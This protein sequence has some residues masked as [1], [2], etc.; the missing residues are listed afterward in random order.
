M[1]TLS[2]STSARTLSANYVGTD[3]KIKSDTY[4]LED[5]G[6]IY[7]SE[8]FKS[9]EDV[10]INNYS[11]IYLTDKR[12]GSDFLEFDLVSEKKLQDI[13]TPI[14]FNTCDSGDGLYLYIDETTTDVNKELYPCT[15]LAEK[16]IYNNSRKYF[17]IQI[18]D[19]VYCRIAH[20]IEGDIFYLTANS[21]DE[22]F[23][24]KDSP[25]FNN[26]VDDTVFEYFID[27]D[28]LALVKEISA[29][30]D[31]IYRRVLS[32]N[33]NKLTLNN[34][35]SG[36]G[37]L[38]FSTNS[39]FRINN[40]SKNKNLLPKLDISWV[41]YN[42]SKN[43]INRSRSL[44]DQK[45]NYLATTQYTYATGNSIDVSMFSLK[46]TLTDSN[47][48]QRGDYMTRYNQD[49]VPSVNFKTYKTLDTGRFEETGNKNISIT[50]NFYNKNYEFSPDE[51]NVFTTPSVLYPY[52]Q[53]NINDS[54]FFKNGSLYGDSPHTSDRIYKKNIDSSELA[55]T[56][57]YLC[58]WLSGS[59]GDEIWLDRYYI[60]DKITTSEALSSSSSTIYNYKTLGKALKEENNIDGDYFDVESMLTFY[61]NQ[62][63]I[64]Q[65]IGP[66]YVSR[67]LEHLDKDKLL[68]KFQ[69]K[70]S[71]GAALQ[72]PDELDKNNFR[73]NLENNYFLTNFNT[74]DNIDSQLTLSFW[75]KKGDWNAPIG[76]QIL[77]SYTNQGISV[78]NDEAITPFVYIQNTSRTVIDVYN[79]IGRR[80]F[81]ITP[82]PPDSLETIIDIIRVKHLDDF[83][84]ITDARNLYKIQSNGATYDS[85]KIVEIAG[86]T[87]Y[88]LDGNT[89]YILENTNGDYVKIDLETEEV[90]T[91][92]KVDIPIEDGIAY[93]IRSIIVDYNGNVSGFRGSKTIRYDSKYA[94]SLIENVALIK[95]S[96]DHTERTV[97]AQS[98]ITD[99]SVEPED[100][101]KD[102]TIHNSSLYYI[103]G[104]T[105]LQKVDSEGIILY[106]ENIVPN[107]DSNITLP[108]VAIDFVR[109][110]ID[111][112]LVEYPIVISEG[113]RDI[114]G[115]ITRV[116]ERGD[117]RPE[118]VSSSINTVV[119][120]NS[121]CDTP[122]R[123][124][125]TS[126]N[127]LKDEKS[128][129]NILKFNFKF[130]NLNNNRDFLQTQ[131][132]YDVS[133]FIAGSNHHFAIRVDTINGYINVFVDT[134]RVFEYKF[135]AAKYNLS[136]LLND[137]F[138]IGSTN[139]YNNILLSEVLK[140]PNYYFCSDLFM[141]QP[142]FYKTAV[143]DI[144]VKFLYLNNVNIGKM[145]A[146]LPAG[147]NN[148]VE[149]IKTYFKWR[150]STSKS[151]EINLIIKGGKIGN[152]NALVE[153]I[154]QRIVDDISATLPASTNIKNIT[155][156]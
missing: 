28:T 120:F 42:E 30:G 45:S 63:Y 155:I 129:K 118:T 151:N 21:S 125:L 144:D 66:K 60:P 137:G 113:Y 122:I 29:A 154:K 115:Y 147:N 149:T 19:N 59:N 16:D 4:T 104:E 20:N 15:L 53:L 111:G 143:K 32:V 110:Y 47:V 127:Y 7:K 101:I 139:F 136:N 150:N 95:E 1:D 17:E 76:H 11:A 88:A 70:T 148:K 87:N 41:S 33:N 138:C 50:Y 40:S 64:Y 48:V 67:Y 109:E 25:D 2:F 112:K 126:Y 10:K 119:L 141:E 78:S 98:N 38:L 37:N 91:G 79:T 26:V 89:L 117:S 27:I 142:K 140:L 134:K 39:K 114:F 31:D 46:N 73:Y 103:I 3:L 52:K 23:F 9:A 55:N 22:I 130:K 96:Y 43:S 80:L 74:R 51:Y 82:L 124:N 69:L 77:G 75:L 68:D 108:T 61:P 49:N 133:E 54:L 72:L 94:I 100:L 58:T 62:E 93:D 85:K 44:F 145:S 84:I 99:K 57:S 56:G 81:T 13:V 97:I 135:N 132:N 128:N 123:Y 92:Y 146:S 18:I 6:V 102:F 86:Y 71:G 116:K 36:G 83:Y 65:R 153:Q 106:S 12:S 90:L 156:R 107:P 152:N 24:R 105:L 8:I 35:N 131:F 121:K 5:N 14:Y 34:Y